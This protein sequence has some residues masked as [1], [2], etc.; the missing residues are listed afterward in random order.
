MEVMSG[1]SGEAT[2]L[3]RTVELKGHLIDSL[4]LS[5]VID[6]VQQLGGDY[7]LNDIRIGSLKKD[8]TAI[9]MTLSAPDEALLKAILEMLTPYGA[10]PAEQE[11]VSTVVCDA[12]G[13]APESAYQV[14]L[15][16]QAH[17]DGNWIPVAQGGVWVMVLN[18][19]EAVMK[20]LSAVRRGDAL[21]RGTQGLHW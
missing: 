17:V 8:I 10:F 15:P 12:D 5:K 19:N 11:N 7:R 14:K 21:V 18:G 9:N 3:T 1:I 4:T 2:A 13:Q 16:T 20:P 6:R